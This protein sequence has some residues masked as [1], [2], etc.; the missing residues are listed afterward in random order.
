MAD[1]PGGRA[2]GGGGLGALAGEDVGHDHLCALGHE[3]A[4][5]GLALAARRSG[6]DR[7]QSVQTSHDTSRSSFRS[8]RRH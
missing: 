2:D 1:E 5:L 7:R 8:L 3:Q 4:S 6:D